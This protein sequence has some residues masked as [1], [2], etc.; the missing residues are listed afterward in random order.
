MVP[1]R[2]KFRF[3]RCVAGPAAAL[4]K[5]RE[6]EG[7]GEEEGKFARRSHDKTLEMR[8]GLF[9]VL[10]H[11]HCVAGWRPAVV[12]A[13][14]RMR[15]CVLLVPRVR[16]VRFSFHCCR[17]RKKLKVHALSLVV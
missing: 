7:G 14:L 12:V 15:R 4:K 16:S 1:S 8:E 3:V 9:V 13:I 17:M 2:I 5:E 11:K 6:I 10:A